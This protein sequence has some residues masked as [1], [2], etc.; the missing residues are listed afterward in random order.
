MRRLKRAVALTAL[1]PCLAMAAPATLESPAAASAQARKQADVGLALTKVSPKTIRENSKIEISGVAKNRTDGR[2]GGLSVRLRYGTQPV[3]SRSQLDQ[4]ASARPQQLPNIGP[5]QRLANTA[6]PGATQNWKFKTSTRALQLNVTAGTPG[7]YPVGVEVLDSAQQVVGG[8]TTFLTFMPKQGNS[9]PVAISWVWPLIDRMH[10]TD[11]KT[12]FDDQLTSDMS[13][14]GRLNTLVDAAASTDTPVTW[15]IDPALLDDAQRMAAGEYTVNPLGSGKPVQKGKSMVAAAWLA[16]LKKALN[17]DPYFTV[18]YGDPDVVALV[19]HKMTRDID[20][21]FDDRNT[22]VATQALGRPADAHVAWPPHGAGGPGTLE[23]LS[24]NTLKDGGAFLMS[25][26]QF[27]NPPTGAPPNAATA[28]QTEAGKK[29]ALL[30]DEKLNKIVSNGK[31][32]PLQT[33][34]RF[35]AETA[36]IAA[37]APNLQRTVVVAPDRHW[38]PAPGLAENLLQY[39]QD[40]EWLREMPLSKIES[41]GAQARTFNGYP[42]AFERYELGEAHLAQVR[43]VSRRAATFQSVLTNDINISHE[44]A[45]LR[46]QSVAWRVM[47]RRAKLVRNA[48]ADQVES[49]MQQVRIVT[50]KNKRVLMGGSSGKLPVLVENTLSNQSVKV[51]LVASS[52]NSAKLQLGELDPEEAVIELQPGERAQRW[53][54]AQA[55]GNGNFRV[56]LDLV[57]PDSGGRTLGSGETITVVTTGYG[58]LALLITGGGLAVLFVGVG[59]RAIRARRRRKAEAGGDGSTGVGPAG[60]GEPGDGFSGPGFA[61]PGIPASELPGTGTPTPGPS[62]P[63]T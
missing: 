40:A 42:D 10:R 27:Q 48:L 25:S 51:R 61:Q 29:D 23:Q 52:E 7:V 33:E 2:L 22:G 59:V 45:L 53:I 56:R 41:S 62:A 57:I 15:G 12:F 24:K 17:G 55:A 19:R 60:A 49:D 6:E 39:T 13:P 4:F 54:P 37:E 16:A 47:P 46:M 38:N 1:L 9:K 31:A 14:N 43:A 63:G 11:D 34:Q 32:G 30:Y 36:M 18:P 50:T 5:Q 26:S 28:I 58:Q 8:V 21:A 35:L 20:V 3:S 44:R